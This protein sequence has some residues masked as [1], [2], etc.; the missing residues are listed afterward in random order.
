MFTIHNIFKIETNI[1]LT[2]N[3]SLIMNVI[4]KYMRNRVTKVRIFFYLLLKQRSIEYAD[5]VNPSQSVE[6]SKKVF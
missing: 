1:D 2:A 5:D 4:R 6:L 3:I